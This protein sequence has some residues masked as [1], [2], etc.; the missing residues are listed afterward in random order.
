MLDSRYFNDNGFW[1]F[2]NGKVE[3]AGVVADAR[4]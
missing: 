4:S 1:T 3:V 2:L